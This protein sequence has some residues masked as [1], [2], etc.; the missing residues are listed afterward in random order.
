M[1]KSALKYFRWLW[2]RSEGVRW[3]LFW[4][5]FLGIVNIGLNLY[6]I[7]LCKQLVDI[8]TGVSS[9][10]LALNTALVFVVIILRLVVAAY[11]TRLENLTNS[12]MNFIIRASLFSDIVGARWFGREKHHTGDTVNRLETDVSTVTNVICTDLPQIVTTI[13]HLIAAVIFLALM[14]WK[15]ALVLVS[16]TPLLVLISKVFFRKMRVL[17]KRI[18]ETESKVQSHLQETLQHRVVVQSMEKGALMGDRLDALQTMEYGQIVERTRFNIISRTIV[19]AS[20]SF[21]YIAAFLWGVYGIHRGVTSFGMMTAFLQL[22]GQ[23][24]RP[25]VN[26]MRQ[27]PSFIYAT[28]SIDRLMELETL[29]KEETGD[30]VRIAGPVG[31]RLQDVS[32]RYP[33]GD[34]DILKQ[35]TFDFRPGDRIAIKG[36]TGAG[37]STLIRLMLALLHPTSGRV[38]LYGPSGEEVEASPLTRCNIVYVPQGNSLFSGTVRDNLLMGDP[39]ASETAMTEA[40]K[41]AVADFVLDLPEGLDTMCGE[42][43]AGLSEGQ[44]QRIAI[45]R[46]LLRSG[47]VMLLDEFSSSLDPSTESR[48]MENL[49]AAYPSKTMIFITHREKI[50]EYCTSTLKLERL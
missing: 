49:V 40:L 23:V 7:F 42:G 13:V 30:P 46:G 45:A 17:T 25:I 20:F 38:S 9:G 32:F 31:I 19:T 3:A 39:D 22:V 8:A 28:A 6:F 18:R 50:A 29:P 36:E 15:L 4:N 47:S 48:L 34:R 27:I 12:R 44:A 16:M 26:L 2:R 14:D 41:T 21:G 33:D 37:K 24:Q 35:L 1:L 43:G 5:I 10:S 11:N